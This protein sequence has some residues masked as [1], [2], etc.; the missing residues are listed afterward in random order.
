[1]ALVD[2]QTVKEFLGITGSDQDAYLTKLIGYATDAIEKTAGRH[3]ER[4]T[5][6]D[7]RDGGGEALILHNRPIEEITKILD[8]AEPEAPSEVQPSQYTLDHEAGYVLHQPRGSS[9]PPESWYNQ[10]TAGARRWEITYVGGFDPVPGDII[11]AALYTIEMYVKDASGGGRYA[12]ESLG[13][14]SYSLS[15]SAL[16]GQ[17]PPI[18]MNAV[19]RYKDDDF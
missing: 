1:M 13:D 7:V 19:M 18:A 6:T 2:L 8:F 5:Y 12:S 15:E 11:S 9:G 16:K 3:F 17:L 4:A 14:Y 10:W